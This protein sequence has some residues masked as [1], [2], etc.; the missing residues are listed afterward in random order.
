MR[1]I[2]KKPKNGHAKASTSNSGMGQ[3]TDPSKAERIAKRIARAG[4]CS[5]R[6]AER[7]IEEGEVMVNG[8]VISSPALNVT[9]KDEII[10]KGKKLAAPETAR[11]W[12][13]YKPRGLVVSAKD[14]KGRETIFDNLPE[15]LPRVVSVGRL[16]IDSEGL[17][18]LTN[19]GDLA[20]HLELPATGWSRKYK[21]R[22]QGR[23]DE[24]QLET[25][26]DGITVDG[27]R[28]GPIE[29][30]LEIQKN[31]NAWLIISIREG[32]N[33]EVRRIMEHLGH[34]VSRLIR[35][36]YGPFQLGR[37]DKG[38]IE[39]IRPSI[40]KEQLGLADSKSAKAG[41]AG[42]DKSQ[43]DGSRAHKGK[44]QRS[45]P[46]KPKGKQLSLAKGKSEGRKLAKSSRTGAKDAD[47]R[48][49]QTRR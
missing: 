27:V 4:I 20:R 47:H 42:D 16:D 39:E 24:K 30:R 12:R 13:Y 37:L 1:D 32:K 33:R 19:D 34:R 21:V 43:S 45:K 6:D 3:K 49:K 9:A 5:R 7:L 2:Y 23:V 41:L 29:A 38:E 44:A 40:L 11:L 35:L 48:R 22:V 17:L 25:I 31:A 46:F 10:V 18:L 28:Y 26:R 14:E 15:N 8:E 36:S